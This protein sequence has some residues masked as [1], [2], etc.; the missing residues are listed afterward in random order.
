MTSDKCGRITDEIDT[1]G[2]EKLDMV[3][4]CRA[5][6]RAYVDV[7]GVSPRRWW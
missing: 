4:F 5:V 2:G 1:L 6:G 3:H 7:G